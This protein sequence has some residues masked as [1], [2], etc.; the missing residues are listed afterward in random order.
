MAIRVAKL[1]AEAAVPLIELTVIEHPRRAAKGQL[2]LADA[3]V[4]CRQTPHKLAA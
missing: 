4:L 3:A 2:R 1:D